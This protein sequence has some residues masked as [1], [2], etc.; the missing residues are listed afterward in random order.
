[1][2]GPPCSADK[3]GPPEKFRPHPH[4]RPRPNNGHPH[5]AHLK[6]KRPS[7]SNLPVGLFSKFCWPSHVYLLSSPTPTPNTSR[8]V[9][10]T[11]AI[12]GKKQIN[13]TF[14][15]RQVTPS[16]TRVPYIRPATQRPV[17]EPREEPR[18]VEKSIAEGSREDRD[19]RQQ[20]SF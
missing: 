8:A 6:P 9:P 18:T 14:K 2:H 7:P 17:K 3:L 4:P 20:I 13:N 12:P 19:T 11:L 1:M 5:P 15:K 16:S 10:Y